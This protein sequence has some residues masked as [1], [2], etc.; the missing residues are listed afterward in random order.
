MAGNIGTRTGVVGPMKLAAVIATTIVA[1]AS[2]ARAQAPEPQPVLFYATSPCADLA[3]HER[4]T[5]LQRLAV[6]G[7]D[8]VELYRRITGYGYVLEL[9]VHVGAHTTITTML[10]IDDC[11]A[12]TCVDQT[13]RNARLR[14]LD[15]AAGEHAFGLDLAVTIEI[16]HT[17]K[18]A[19]PPSDR[20]ANGAVG[21]VVTPDGADCLDVA[22]HEHF[23]RCR[24]T[25]WRGT[26]VLVAC[27]DGPHEVELAAPRQ[28]S[29]YDAARVDALMQALS[30]ETFADRTDCA[31]LTREATVLFDG[32]P[33][34]V[35]LVPS[36]AHSAAVQNQLQTIVR[37]LAIE[38][39]ACLD[40][41]ALV[42]TMRRL[43]P[44]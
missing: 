5:R 35:A 27:D 3:P 32:N 25:G 36:L 1:L 13:L 34:I 33:E 4:C 22:L 30:N 21:C 17:Y 42:A 6:P 10:G 29:S 41:A 23:P 20:P 44:S 2:V 24:T 43:A 11:S 37:I 9:A 26:K 8:G 14:R 31:K 7:T 19:G 18:E 15:T 16:S 40:D 12:G 28:P 39:R 38:N